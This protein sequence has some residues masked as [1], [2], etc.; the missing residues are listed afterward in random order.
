MR[1][2]KTNE[3]LTG[4]VCVCSV[5][6]PGIVLGKKKTIFNNTKETARV[7]FG[8]GLDGKGNWCSTNPAIIAESGVEFYEKLSERFGGKM[9]F[10]S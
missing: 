8:L 1:L 9:S 7:W 3:D 6:R 10:N 4:K 2:P 5:G